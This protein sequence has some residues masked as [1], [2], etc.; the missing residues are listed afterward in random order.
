[1]KKNSH[2][3]TP[4]I[5]NEASA[6]TRRGLFLGAA[7]GGV[8]AALQAAAETPMAPAANPATMMSDAANPALQMTFPFYAPKGRRVEQAGISTPPQRYTMFMSFDLTTQN[9]QAL[10]VLLAR[11]S[12][13][14]SLLMQGKTIGAVEPAHPDARGLDSGEALDLGPAGLTVTL[15]LGPRVFGPDF[16]LAAHR[17]EFLADLP[18]MPSDELR[19]DFTGGDLS[20]Q[21]CAEDPQVA[22]HAIRDLTRIGKRL[23]AVATRWTQMGFGRASAGKG[24]ITPRN[25][26]GFRDG[27]RNIRETDEFD[28]YVWLGAARQTR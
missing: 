27:T 11:W 2:I 15:G 12:A 26:F 1:M 16:G 13:A 17:P 5:C 10:Q 7:A 3:D 8:A 14:I 24:Q 23:G 21:A 22:Y 28:D 20:L 6:V 4:D 19:P 25:L 18:P 9:R